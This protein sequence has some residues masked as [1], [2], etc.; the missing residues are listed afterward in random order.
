LLS[1][2]YKD[3]LQHDECNILSHWKK[4]FA[5]NLANYLCPK[6]KLLFYAAGF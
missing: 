5:A 3:T 1:L 6:E 4:S 2:R